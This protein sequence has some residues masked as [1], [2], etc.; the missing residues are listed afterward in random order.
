MRFG[1]YGSGPVAEVGVWASAALDWPPRRILDDRRDLILG[2][3]QR[4]QALLRRHPVFQPGQQRIDPRQAGRGGQQ[5]LCQRV[6]SPQ[7]GVDGRLEAPKLLLLL[8]RAQ[9]LPRFRL[10]AQSLALAGQVSPEEVAL[11]GQLR[12]EE[13]ALIGDLGFERCPYRAQL[14]ER[15]ADELGLVALPLLRRA[16]KILVD[17]ELPF[18]VVEA[19]LQLLLQRPFFRKK[20]PLLCNAFLLRLV[21]LGYLGRSDLQLVPV[22]FEP[23]EKPRYD[24]RMREPAEQRSQRRRARGRGRDQHAEPLEARDQHDL[25]GSGSLLQEVLDRG[26]HA[27]PGAAL[28]CRVVHVR[29]EAAG[30]E[31]LGLVQVHPLLQERL[32]KFRGDCGGVVV[33][34]PATV[35]PTDVVQEDEGKGVPVLPRGSGDELQLVG[36]GVPVVVAIDEDRVRGADLRQGVEAALLVKVESGRE[37]PLPRGKIELWMRIDR[38]KRPVVAIAIGEQVLGIATELRADLDDHAGLM[39]R[40]CRFDDCLPEPVHRGPPRDDSPT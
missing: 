14:L 9:P 26:Q 20:R 30:G 24:V 36:D 28:M 12:A 27:V 4:L 13:R 33:E 35:R 21:P 32:P 37:S 3:G 7:G 25:V 19:P 31:E 18:D 1:S 5:R 6:L 11:L 16:K 34:I 29:I 2:G 40:Q 39:Q 22:A 17:V 23:V 10:R 8:S 38:M 15:L